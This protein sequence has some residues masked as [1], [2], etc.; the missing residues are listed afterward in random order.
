MDSMPKSVWRYQKCD[1]ARR[2]WW[3][4]TVWRWS[5]STGERRSTLRF[6]ALRLLRRLVGEEG[7]ILLH[8]TH[9]APR[10]GGEVARTSLY[11]GQ[12]FELTTMVRDGESKD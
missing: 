5:A 6:R 9:V 7:G 1:G 12:F 10:R 3:C 2:M 11:A 4:A 8:D